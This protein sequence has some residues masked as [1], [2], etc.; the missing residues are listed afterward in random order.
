MIV[1][2]LLLLLFCSGNSY[3]CGAL[4]KLYRKAPE[5]FRGDAAR[6]QLALFANKD[7]LGGNVASRTLFGLTEAFA[8]LIPVTNVSIGNAEK[9]EKD[10]ENK[11]EKL[12]KL[13]EVAANIREDYEKIFWATGNMNTELWADD[14]FFADPFSSFGGPGKGQSTKRFKANADALGKLV[15]DPS[16]RITSFEVV[17]PTSQLMTHMTEE[18][19]D[20]E[21]D[22]K[23]V[24]KVDPKI[25]GKGKGG[26]AEVKVGWIFTS[27]LNLPWKP[28]LAAAGSTSHVLRE[29]DLR[30]VEYR[31]KWKSKPWDVVKRLFIPT[32]TKSTGASTAASAILIASTLGFSLPLPLPISGSGLVRADHH[33]M[34][35]MAADYPYPALAAAERQT[36]DLFEAN[37]PSVVYISTFSE[38]LDVLNMNVLEVPAGTGT[39]F[40]WD[41]QGH[42]VTNY[43]VIRSARTAKVTIKSQRPGVA[44]LVRECN[45]GYVFV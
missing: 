1:G 18:E 31:E 19:E 26:K 6:S 24:G 36:I 45:I 37:T 23:E 22:P 41:T 16:I 4:H 40:V 20:P 33:Q 43:H 8:K 38:K 27:T 32:K 28:V 25:T 30:I 10:N 42:I 34:T 21:V 14:C 3:N 2:I 17:P 7:Y 9:A 12:T 44:P 15:L 13:D 29:G 5:C 39:G 11:T 35:A